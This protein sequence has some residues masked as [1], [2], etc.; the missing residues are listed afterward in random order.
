MKVT[1]QKLSIIE[2]NSVYVQYAWIIDYTNSCDKDFV[3]YPVLEF[4][5]ESG[6]LLDE[7]SYPDQILVPANGTAQAKGSKMIDPV[8]KANRITHTSAGFSTSNW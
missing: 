3:G 1:D 8:S 4:L 2:S 5:D 7:L 6:F